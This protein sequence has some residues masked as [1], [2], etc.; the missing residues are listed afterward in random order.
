MGCDIHVYLEKKADEKYNIWKQ[1]K[2]YRVSPYSHELEVADPYVGRNYDL[3]SILAGVRGWL[4]PLETPRGLPHD[5]S[6]GVEKEKAWWGEDSHTHTW[7]D[8]HELY[9]Y[10]QIYRDN[11][12]FQCFVDF[13]DDIECYL[14][15][16][17]KHYF[18]LRPGQYRVVMWFDN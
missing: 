3:F 1:V 6:D 13:V 16:A 11:E 5:L 18:D 14:R 9:L 2:L 8:L 12:E 17:E 7:Y 4:K 15:L 10:R